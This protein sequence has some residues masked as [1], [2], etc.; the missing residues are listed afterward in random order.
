MNPV[1]LVATVVVRK[2]AVQPF[3]RFPV[4]KPETTTNPDRIPT[5][6]NAT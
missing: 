6:L 4:T 5:R 1:T 3:S 2:S